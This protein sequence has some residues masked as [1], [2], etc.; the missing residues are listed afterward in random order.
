[1]FISIGSSTELQDL[2]NKSMQL[3]TSVLSAS[4]IIKFVDRDGMSN[5]EVTELFD[6]KQIKT[7]SLRNIECYLLDD[8]IIE[9]LCNIQEK[10]DLLQEC[11]DA[12]QQAISNSID[13]GNPPDDIKSASGDTCVAIKRILQLTQSGNSTGAFLRDTMTPLITEDTNIY[14]LLES[15]IFDRES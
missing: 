5:Q 3:L 10:S 4:E 14:Q 7:S 12:K 15:E 11:L 9:K 6:D 13:R 2:D 1:M 8:E